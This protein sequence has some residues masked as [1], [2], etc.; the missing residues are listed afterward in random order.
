MSDIDQDIEGHDQ[1]AVTPGTGV[2]AA[3]D[4]RGAHIL[5]TERNVHEL[6]DAMVDGVFIASDFRFVFCNHAMADLVGVTPERFIG[7]P[8]ST[9]VTAEFLGIWT[10]RFEKRINGVRDVPRRYEV[11]LLNGRARSEIWVELIATPI[12][13]SDQPSVLGIVRDISDRKTAEQVI[14]AQAHLDVVTRLPNRF[15]L[16]RQL[17]DA[18]ENARQ[19]AESLALLFIDLDEFKQI[20]DVYGHDHGDKVLAQLAAQ[21]QACIGERELLARFGGDEFNVLCPGA[22]SDAAI[23]QIGERL[24]K[25]INSPFQL[26]GKR[27]QV[28]ASIGAARFP[29][30]ADNAEDLLRHADQAMYDAKR[31][32]SNKLRLFHRELD[33]ANRRKGAIT[34]G[35]DRALREDELFFLYQPIV[36]IQTMSIDKAEALIRWRDLDGTIIS[37]ADFITVA[38]DTGRIV[39]IGNHMLGVALDFG[40]ACRRELAESFQVTVNIS[41]VQLS[42]I[43]SKF[44]AILLQRA[45]ENRHR[46]PICIELTEST[47]LDPRP[48]V[49]ERLRLLQEVGYAVAIDDFGTGYS[50]L[51]YLRALDVDYVKI[52]RAFI[53]N[54]A[55]GNKDFHILKA[56]VMLAHEIGARVIAE[57]IETDRQFALVRM[58]GCDFAQGY[59]FSRPLMPDALVETV[60]RFNRGR[61]DD[62]PG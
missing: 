15:L 61:R 32:G 11:R 59:H 17:E 26:G 14:W 47:F 6:L 7:Q 57:G 31:A 29:Q 33:A 4:P 21:L 28:R 39:E 48:H 16:T 2:R 20:N 55:R 40:L 12:R 9:F 56:I 23:E 38:E 45:R 30:D 1:D 22:G 5:S 8:F 43:D 62:K 51:S 44:E 13:F 58:S 19:R 46:A 34:S 36:N 25:A 24:L 50:A 49:K 60:Q 53:C 52:D 3:N 37:P 18:L 42:D 41:A 54:L 35:L 27:L 10:E